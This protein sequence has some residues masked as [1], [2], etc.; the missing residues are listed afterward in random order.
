MSSP[1]STRDLGHA[2]GTRPTQ[3]E[4]AR[5]IPGALPGA[6]SA[7]CAAFHHSALEAPEVLSG[8]AQAVDPVRL[9]VPPGR[10]Q[11]PVCKK[12]GPQVNGPGQLTKGAVTQA[13][14]NPRCVI[15]TSKA[16]QIV[17]VAALGQ[18]SRRASRSGTRSNRSPRDPALPGLFGVVCLAMA[19]GLL[20]RPSECLQ[21]RVQ[22]RERAHSHVEHLPSSQPHALR[23]SQSFRAPI[24]RPQPVDQGLGSMLQSRGRSG[25]ERTAA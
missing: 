23:E 16:F 11:S 25:T 1:V 8:H 2:S 20:C 10:P 7:V 24:E 9:A 12:P 4:N 17:S 21:S 6:T 13:H 22:D 3:F 14:E 15:I 19:D 5:T 18:S